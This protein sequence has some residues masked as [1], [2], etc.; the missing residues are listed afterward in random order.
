MFLFKKC[1]TVLYI[2]L[3][4]LVICIVRD[5]V[6]CQVVFATDVLNSLIQTSYITW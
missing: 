4:E 5:I 3:T 2:W 6:T 1:L